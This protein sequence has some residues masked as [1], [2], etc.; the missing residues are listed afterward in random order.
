MPAFVCN[1]QLAGKCA[2][3]LLLSLPL[4]INREKYSSSFMLWQLLPPMERESP[5]LRCS[6]LTTRSFSCTAL[7]KVAA[8]NTQLTGKLMMQALLLLWYSEVNKVEG[9]KSQAFE[10][11]MSPAACNWTIA[12]RVYYQRWRINQL[13]LRAS[14]VDFSVA[15]ARRPQ[16]MNVG[17]KQTPEWPKEQSAAHSDT[18]LISTCSTLS[19]QQPSLWRPHW[20][21]TLSIYNYYLL[22]WTC[23]SSEGSVQGLC[24]KPV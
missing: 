5:L 24:F 19:Q 11:K 2:L 15:A 13:Y 16:T 6:Q 18:H 3:M 17:I 23:I 9:R 10:V 22:G 7:F 1:F 12:Y 20:T 4:S 21:L 8:I 14:C